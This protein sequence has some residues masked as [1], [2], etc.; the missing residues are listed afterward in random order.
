MNVTHLGTETV[1]AD[2]YDRTR[3]R[4]LQTHCP[5]CWRPC[6]PMDRTTSVWQN[7]DSCSDPCCK[8]SAINTSPQHQQKRFAAAGHVVPDQFYLTHVKVSLKLKKTK[9]KRCCI[10]IYIYWQVR[11]EHEEKT[12]GSVK[13]SALT[14]S[15]CQLPVNFRFAGFNGSMWFTPKYSFRNN[16]TA[17]LE[18]K[19][20][21]RHYMSP[22]S[23]LAI[24]GAC[25]LHLIHT[26]WSL[27]WHHLVTSHHSQSGSIKC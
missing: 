1:V 25:S 12:R 3:G 2:F 6:Y 26:C 17:Y 9:N 22:N 16:I 27:R 4:P 5:G 24:F 11:V 18:I 8:P 14:G 20:Y 21:R 7:T 10:C 19:I 15:H 23:G 13:G